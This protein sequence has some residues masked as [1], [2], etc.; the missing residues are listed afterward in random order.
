VD[1]GR[2]YV[3]DLDRALA[4]DGATAPYL[5]YAYV[6]T[7]SIAARAA[8]SAPGPVCL[9]EPAERRLA[10]CL[11]AFD[12]VVAE[13][14]GSLRPHRLARY[15]VELAEAFTGFFEHCPVLRAQPTLRAGRLTLCDL[16]G[17]TLRLGLDL[18]GI[19]TP[20]RM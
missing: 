7:R 17:R 1:R 13:V 19:Q 11:L 20:D 2:D 4:L 16:T 5:Q 3:F 9:V 14:A 8:D 12:G 6:R 18:L 15:L 10:L